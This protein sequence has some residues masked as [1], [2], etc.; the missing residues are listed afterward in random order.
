MLTSLRRQ[1][2]LFKVGLDKAEPLLDDTLDIS[3]TFS[4][5]THNYHDC[6]AIFSCQPQ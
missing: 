3:T 1:M 5:I 4:Y 6:S 2:Y